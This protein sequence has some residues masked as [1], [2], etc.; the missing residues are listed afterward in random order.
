[1]T[2]LHNR[3]TVLN[4][5]QINFIQHW[6]YKPSIHRDR[7]QSLCSNTAFKCPPVKIKIHKRSNS[8]SSLITSFHST[9]IITDHPI[10]LTYFL[11]K[12]DL[13][14]NCSSSFF[15][16]KKLIRNNDALITDIICNFKH[17][18]N[19]IQSPCTESTSSTLCYSQN[20]ENNSNLEEI[21]TQ[22]IKETLPEVIDSKNNSP[23][24]IMS[25]VSICLCVW[26]VLLSS[27]EVN[28]K[29]AIQVY[30]ADQSQIG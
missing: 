25:F 13:S 14:L 8:S 17:S 9:D 30:P 28:I 21:S 22:I 24:R 20:E 29:S 6:N 19:S 12:N 26:S 16:N 15:K 7:T 27:S 1:M 3:L 10:S 2:N 4:Q 18:R 5:L 23:D 11:G